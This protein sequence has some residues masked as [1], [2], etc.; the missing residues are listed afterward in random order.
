VSWINVYEDED[1]RSAPP[2]HSQ[3]GIDKE[4]FLQGELPVNLNE[5]RVLSSGSSITVHVKSDKIKFAPFSETLQQLK[6]AG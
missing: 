3:G 2:S 4:N 5:V 6:E 1:T